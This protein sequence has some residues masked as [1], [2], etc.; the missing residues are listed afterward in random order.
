MARP[1]REVPPPLE[2]NDRFITA[3]I[4]AGWAIALVVVVLVRHQLP[5]SGHLWIWTCVTGFGLGLFGLVYVP[6][7]KRSRAKATA[8]RASASAEA[9]D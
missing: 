8:R 1:Q 4:T 6:Y 2:G 5:D 9:G 3:V 7:L